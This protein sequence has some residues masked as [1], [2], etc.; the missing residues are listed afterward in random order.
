MTPV[1][2]FF[3]R[4]PLAL[5]LGA[6]LAAPVWAQDAPPSPVP[7]VAAPQEPPS[8]AIANPIPLIQAPPTPP[9]HPAFRASDWPDD[10]GRDGLVVPSAWLWARVGHTWDGPERAHRLADPTLWRRHPDTPEGWTID[11]TSGPEGWIPNSP[12]A[13]PA[14]QRIAF[15]LRAHRIPLTVEERDVWE[16]ARADA[17]PRTWSELRS[18]APKAASGVNTADDSQ[19]WVDANSP[20]NPDPFPTPAP[21]DGAPSSPLPTQEGLLPKMRQEVREEALSRNA[22]VAPEAVRAF[23][24]EAVSSTPIDAQKAP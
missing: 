20:Q 11:S 14:A 10:S 5:L 9:A 12:N 24:N 2:P 15:A 7:S 8:N 21:T 18:A 1:A 23:L 3:A 17:C 22:I 13:C 4:V 19:F 16:R 6:A